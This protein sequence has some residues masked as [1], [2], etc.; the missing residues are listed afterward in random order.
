MLTNITTKGIATRWSG[1]HTNNY[2]Q[3]FNMSIMQLC[4]DWVANANEKT[5]PYAFGKSKR[6]K[7]WIKAVSIRLR[8]HSN[9]LWC[10]KRVIHRSKELTEN[11]Y[12]HIFYVALIEVRFI[13]Y[14]RTA[15]CSGNHYD[16]SKSSL[17]LIVEN[18]NVLNITN[19]IV[20]MEQ[21]SNFYQFSSI[22]YVAFIH[23]RK[24]FARYLCCSN[25]HHSN[26]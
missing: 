26:T 5:A 21:T 15:V 6:T 4:E 22:I 19:F 14:F 3:K 25:I 16:N 17:F 1:H 18:M 12:W 20:E 24:I 7:I 13:W 10:H 11:V 8:H 23:Q 9:R 2:T